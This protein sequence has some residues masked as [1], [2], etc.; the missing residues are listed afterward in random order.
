MLLDDSSDYDIVFM[1]PNAR[2]SASELK[3]SFEKDAL[4]TLHHNEL[5]VTAEGRKAL[6]QIIGRGVARMISEG[7][8]S[9]NISRAEA[10]LGSLIAKLKDNFERQRDGNSAAPAYLGQSNS[11]EIFGLCPPPYWPFC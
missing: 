2:Q 10:S 11:A 7:A 6:S 8:T 5:R 9:Q 4:S 1:Q 3:E